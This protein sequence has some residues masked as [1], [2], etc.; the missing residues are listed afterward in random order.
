M[1]GPHTLIKALFNLVYLSTST[2]CLEKSR[3]ETP[4]WEYKAI[5]IK[6]NHSEREVRSTEKSGFPANYSLMNSGGYEQ[7]VKRS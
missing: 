3:Q 5:I 6:Y 7:T 4:D 1:R 2:A